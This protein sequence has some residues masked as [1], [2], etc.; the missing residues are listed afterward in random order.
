MRGF[1]N[2]VNFAK[3]ISV[4]FGRRMMEMRVKWHGWWRVGFLNRGFPE[5]PFD[6]DSLEE[7]FQ[8]VEALR[9]AGHAP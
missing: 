2:L 5:W 8:E 4:L 6:F 9:S 1:S 3:F 7:V